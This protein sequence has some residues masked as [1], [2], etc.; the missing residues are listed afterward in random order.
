[1]YEKNRIFI[2]TEKLSIYG[3]DIPIILT[4][5]ILHEKGLRFGNEKMGWVIIFFDDMRDIKISQQV[6]KS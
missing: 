2:P 6:S 1:M 3:V 5:Y 4:S